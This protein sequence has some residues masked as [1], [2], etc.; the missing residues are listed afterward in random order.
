MKETGT[1]PESCLTVVQH[2]LFGCDALLMDS[3]GF[4]ATFSLDSTATPATTG[5]S[6]RSPS[7]DF[8]PPFLLSSGPYLNFAAVSTTEGMIQIVATHGMVRLIKASAWRQFCDIDQHFPWWHWMTSARALRFSFGGTKAARGHWSYITEGLPAANLK[9]AYREQ[10]LGAYEVMIRCAKFL[11][12]SAE[13][14]GFRRHQ[15]TA[16]GHFRARLRI[17]YSALSR[18]FWLACR[19]QKVSSSIGR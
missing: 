1:P 7:G 17:G 9:H 6:E 19:R 8:E 16:G 14:E 13:P 2:C 11:A 10:I 15:L 5:N 12:F 18:S 3:P 4:I